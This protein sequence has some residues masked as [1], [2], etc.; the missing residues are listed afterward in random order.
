MNRRTFL[1]TTVGAGAGLLLPGSLL[2]SNDRK[3]LAQGRFTLLHTNDTHA[4][5]DPFPDNHPTLAGLGGIARR[6]AAVKAIRAE[7]PAT[8]LVDAGDIFQGTP[9]FNFYKGALDLELMTDMGYIASTIGNH[10]FDI[11]IDGFCD[12]AKKAGFPFLNCNYDFGKEPMKQFTQPYLVKEI[13]GLRVGFLGVGIQLTGLVL[14][15][16]WGEIVYN[17][18]IEPARKI[19]KHLRSVEKCHIVVCLS[20]IGYKYEHATVSD[21]VL[22]RN[23]PEIDIII[24]GHTHTFMEAPWI[25]DH[26]THKTVVTQAGWGGAVL[27]RLDIAYNGD[28]KPV[29]ISQAPTV[30]DARWA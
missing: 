8:L 7:Q 23:V 24:G 6:S 4:R 16:M 19:A 10:E 5:L 20:H 3:G 1:R 30:I 26:K 21:Q 9:Y 15:S 13:N 2:W 17:D 11:G 12:S 22:A 18:P 28:G 14:A 27:G 25:F 29:A